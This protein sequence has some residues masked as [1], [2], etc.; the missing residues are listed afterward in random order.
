MAGL[1]SGVAQAFGHLGGSSAK[2]DRGNFL[3][4]QQDMKNVFNWALP[5]GQSQA[6]TGQATTAQGVQNLGQ[7]GSYFGKLASGDRAT[8]LQAVAPQTNAALA[9]SDA[10]KAQLANMGTARG[11]GAVGVNQQR[12]TGLMSQIDN[13]LFGARTAGAQ[14]E[15]GVGQAQ[16][17]VGLGQTGQ[18]IQSA[19]LASGTASDMG[20][21]SLYSR[22]VSDEMHRQAVG[23]YAK[24]FGS[25]MGG[26]MGD[27]LTSL[28]SKIGL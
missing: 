6:R 12:D 13:M 23:D 5:F 20:K 3:D 8:A 7:A 21:Q 26:K 1:I 2:T 10:E 25:L 19:G 9:Q 4:A 27:T 22:Q 24:A 28:L 11:G 17:G 15:A 16:A 18:G 14:G